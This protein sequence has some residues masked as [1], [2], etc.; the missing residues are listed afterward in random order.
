MSPK[1]LLGVIPYPPPPLASSTMKIL[2]LNCRGL[3]ILKA[4]EELRCLVR[5]KGPKILFL[6]ETCLDMDGFHK[7]KKK[8]D[9]T[10]GFAVP[11][12]GVGGGLALLWADCMDLD[13]QT[14]SSHHIDALINQ[15]GIVPRFTGFYEYLETL[16]RGE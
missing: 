16:R 13:I 4:G 15:D 3:G 12:I 10:A 2:T 5:E 14:F 9:F 7:L 6:S 11:R 1:K 8:F